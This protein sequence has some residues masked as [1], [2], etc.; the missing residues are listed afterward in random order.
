M[1][2]TNSPQAYC[3]KFHQF[4][5][6]YR[7]NLFIF[8]VE[9]GKELISKVIA[10]IIET[11]LLVKLVNLFD[12]RI[13]ELEGYIQVLFNSLWRFGLGNDRAAMGYAPGLIEYFS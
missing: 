4:S 9:I 3:V 10:R 1:W 12:V 5:L 7:T 8:A 6:Y 2:L 11:K 13:L